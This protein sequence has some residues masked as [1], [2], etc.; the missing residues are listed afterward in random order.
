MTTV[1]I[2]QRLEQ[3]KMLGAGDAQ[4]VDCLSMATPSM[5]DCKD[6]INKTP[7]FTVLVGNLMQQADSLAD[8]SK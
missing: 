4:C 8:Q 5:S 1:A 3:L 6:C 7:A 2:A